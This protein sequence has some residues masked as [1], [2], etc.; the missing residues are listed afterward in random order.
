MGLFRRIASTAGATLG[1]IGSA[2]HR[3]IGRIASTANNVAQKARDIDSASGGVIGDLARS[4]P[5]GQTALKGA[6]L[7]LK[8][9]NKAATYSKAAADIGHGL[10]HY[11]ATG[12]IHPNIAKYR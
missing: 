10:S 11:G 1:R 2:A 7:A 12:E 9:L 5:F 8:G 3:V 4:V 6:D